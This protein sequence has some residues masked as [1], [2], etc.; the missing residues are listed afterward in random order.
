MQPTAKIV[1]DR[2]S[3]YYGKTPVLQ[4]VSVE[5]EERRITAITGPSGSGKSSFL[6]V[7]NRMWT[8]IPGVHL[9]GRAHIRLGDGMHDLCDGKLPA[10]ELR[11]KVGMVFQTPN[12]LPM[13]I[14]RN[15]AFPLKLAG[16]RDRQQIAARVESALRRTLLWD[17][18]KDR[19]KK[20]ARKLSGG[21]Q[22]RLCIARSLVLE[23]EVL[24]LDE[25]TSALDAAAAAG[26][27]ELLLDLKQDCTPVLVSHYLDQVRRLA[28]RIYR[29]ENGE[30][31]A[32]C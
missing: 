2:L 9:T 18:V 23:P 3:F 24:L 5:L 32:E 26:I 31:S 10:G 7:L 29:L 30:L 4:N 8:E 14:Y 11:R 15:V 13:S 21:Q 25:P 6:S 17:E 27:E 20:D 1:T 19:L 22:Q 16:I 12:P 28:D